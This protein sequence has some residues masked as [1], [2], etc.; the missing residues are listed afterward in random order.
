MKKFNKTILDVIGNT[1]IIKIQKLAKH[2]ESEIYVKLEYMNPGGSVKDRLGYVM[3]NEGE[4]LLK[5]L[6]ET[7]E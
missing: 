2:V 5:E 3:C 6:A 1:P 7:Q 4:L